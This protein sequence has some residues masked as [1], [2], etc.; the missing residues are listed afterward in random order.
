MLENANAASQSDG[1]DKPSNLSPAEQYIRQRKEHSVGSH[2][3]VSTAKTASER[4]LNYTPRIPEW[5]NH[6]RAQEIPP[7]VPALPLSNIP[8]GPSYISSTLPEPQLDLGPQFSSENSIGT[9]FQFEHSAPALHMFN[10][11]VQSVPMRS[12]FGSIPVHYERARGGGRSVKI[13]FH[14]DYGHYERAAGKRLPFPDISNLLRNENM[15]LP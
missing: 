8:Q 6:A 14:P 7:G 9:S 2:A 5:L 12:S 1:R 15:P 10:P 3:V 11:T 4:S 13:P